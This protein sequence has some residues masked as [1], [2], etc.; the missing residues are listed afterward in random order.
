MSN[1]KFMYFNLVD[2]AT[3]GL[4]VVSGGQDSFYPLSNLQ[5][6]QA[7]TTFRSTTGQ[8]T[9]VILIDC[10][11]ASLA[12]AFMAV[13][14]SIGTLEL[15]SVTIE[16][17]ATTD[18]TTPAFSTTVTDFDYDNNICS[19]S[20]TDTTYRYWQITFEGGSSYVE[21]AN[22]FLGESQSLTNNNIAIGWTFQNVDRSDV[23]TGRYGQKYIDRINSQKL[24]TASI[25]LLDK[26]EFDVINEMYE[27]CGRTR[28][29]W[30]I[31]DPSELILNNKDFFSGYFYFGQRPA[32]VN[33]FYALYS[34]EFVL[35]EVK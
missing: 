16:A 9:S 6:P 28:P 4:S 5:Q 3:T 25:R 26:D 2:Q 15:T 29:V 27:Y 32:F 22:V 7:C 33:D 31:I 13:G 30:L 19:H 11:A 14:S 24:I 23:S 8:L 35:E 17:N 34:T 10:G 20:F 1:S 18:F 12:N 21:V